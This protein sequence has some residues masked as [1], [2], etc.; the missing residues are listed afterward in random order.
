MN[1][2]SVTDSTTTQHGRRRNSDAEDIRRL[3][4]STD[5]AELRWLQ[6]GNAPTT[7]MSEAWLDGLHVGDVSRGGTA[8]LHPPTRTLLVESNG[9]IVTVLQAAYT[10]YTDDHLVACADCDLEYQPTRD[11]RRCPWCGHDV[12]S[13]DEK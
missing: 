5:H 8:K 4:S 12:E 13:E 3:P 9:C 1:Q 10:Q 7:P 2:M 11:D 6:R